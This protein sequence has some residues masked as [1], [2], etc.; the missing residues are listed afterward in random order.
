MK[1]DVLHAQLFQL[2]RALPVHVDCPLL[3]RGALAPSRLKLLLGLLL[4]QRLLCHRGL[5]LLPEAPQA[6]RVAQLL[7]IN[8]D[9]DLLLVEIPYLRL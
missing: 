5:P 7:G 2:D 4:T 6:V 8:P 9:L 1:F 3:K